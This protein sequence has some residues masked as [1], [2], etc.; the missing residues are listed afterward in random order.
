[1]F[2]LDWTIIAK[3]ALRD[4]RIDILD[5]AARPFVD[6]GFAATLLDRASDEVGST[7][8]AIYY[9]SKPDLFL[10]VHRRAMELAQ[11]AIPPLRESEGRCLSASAGRRRGPHEGESGAARMA[12]SI[13]EFVGGLA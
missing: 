2:R 8:D 10:A 3:A 7:G 9:R 4:R 11:R 6:R 1:M 5:A 12:E 13:G